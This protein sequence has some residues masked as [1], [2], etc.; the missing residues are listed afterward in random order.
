MLASP[1][2]RPPL[3]AGQ[4]LGNGELGGKRCELIGFGIQQGF[5]LEVKVGIAKESSCEDR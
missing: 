4:G 1:V 3:A 2:T 5:P